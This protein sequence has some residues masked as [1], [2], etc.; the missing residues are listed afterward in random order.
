MSEQDNSRRKFIKAAAYTAPVVMT[1]KAAPSFASSG[2]CRPQWNGGG[3]K[4]HGGT[5]SG[6]GK[7]RFGG[8]WSG[9]GKKRSGGTWSGGGKHS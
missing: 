2:S 1:L 5:W 7:K 6:G 4:S 8:T 9:G 3:K